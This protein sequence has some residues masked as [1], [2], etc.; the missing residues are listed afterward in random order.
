MGKLTITVTADHRESQDGPVRDAARE[1]ANGLTKLGFTGTSLVMDFTPEARQ[2]VPSTDKN[3]P[4]AEAEPAPEPKGPQEVPLSGEPVK[5]HETFPTAQAAEFAMGIDSTTKVPAGSSVADAPPVEAEASA[6][7]EASAADKT[8]ASV[9]DKLAL[10]PR[11]MTIDELRDALD[12]EFTVAEL[13]AALAAEKDAAGRVGA[14]E[15]LQRARDAAA[16]AEA[17]AE[18]APV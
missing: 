12:A 2:P 10:D 15:A 6:E 16:E 1:F 11:E 8:D 5:Q 9:I 7:T 14:M 3:E 17:G 4:P 18:V 13:D